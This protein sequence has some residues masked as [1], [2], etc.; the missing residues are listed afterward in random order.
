MSTC[1]PCGRGEHL[2]CP[3]TRTQRVCCCYYPWKETGD[4]VVEAWERYYKTLPD[5]LK[6]KLSVYDLRRLGRG[7]Q[8]AFQPLLEEKRPTSRAWDRLR[9][10][11]TLPEITEE[12]TDCPECGAHTEWTTDPGI[13]DCVACD[14]C[15]AGR[16]DQMSLILHG[17]KKP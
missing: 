6:R 4:E 9:E 3:T 12:S 13:G 16:F 1:E 2:E 17:E 8:A 5:D 11:A 14:S 7:F 15:L 10:L